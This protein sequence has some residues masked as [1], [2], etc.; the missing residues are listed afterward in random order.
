MTEINGRFA[1]LALLASLLAAHCFLEKRLV[2][3]AI[4]QSAKPVGVVPA[5][6]AFGIA[7]LDCAVGAEQSF[8]WLF[9]GAIGSI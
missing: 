4:G 5:K 7:N 2:F 1:I 8:R 6:L 3:P 9:R